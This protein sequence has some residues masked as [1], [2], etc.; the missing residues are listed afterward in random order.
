[1]MGTREWESRAAIASAVRAA[2]TYTGPDPNVYV[3]DLGEGFV[4]V[5]VVFAG[6]LGPEE[7][8]KAHVAAWRTAVIRYNTRTVSV[9]IR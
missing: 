4:V 3:A 1:M 9:V 2:I 6:A 7:V 8:H 5:T